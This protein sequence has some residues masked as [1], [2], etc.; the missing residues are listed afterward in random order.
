MTTWIIHPLNPEVIESNPYFQYQKLL[1][2]C[3]VNPILTPELLK[4]IDIEK[5]IW[6]SEYKKPFLTDTSISWDQKNIILRVLASDSREYEDIFLWYLAYTLASESSKTNIQK[7]FYQRILKSGQNPVFDSINM[8]YTLLRKFWLEEYLH[9]INT[10]LPPQNPEKADMM[11]KVANTTSKLVLSESVKSLSEAWNIADN[12]LLNYLEFRA[13]ILRIAYTMEKSWKL[14]ETDRIPKNL[15]NTL[16]NMN[17]VHEW[18]DDS[19]D[20]LRHSA[21]KITMNTTLQWGSI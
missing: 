14:T 3:K 12:W 13:E 11:T 8:R 9:I 18:K 10:I 16:E 7:S 1:E 6:D 5:A 4:D 17:K 19:D 2:V 15:R 20:E 21:L